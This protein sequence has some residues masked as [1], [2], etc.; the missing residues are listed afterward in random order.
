MFEPSNEP[1]VILSIDGE[2]SAVVLV[3]EN[4][5]NVRTNKLQKLTLIGYFIFNFFA[6]YRLFDKLRNMLII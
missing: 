3:T 4:K 6:G 1:H 5:G 2:I